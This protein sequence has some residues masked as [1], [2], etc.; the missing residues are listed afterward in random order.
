[1]EN[2]QKLAWRCCRGT[3]E[4]DV[5][6]QRFLNNYYQTASGDL[7]HA[8]ERMLDMQDPELYDLLVGRQL[9]EDQNINNVIE[10]IYR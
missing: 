2:L 9:S 3:K 5:L 4:L 1:M 10:H 6:M 8:F 7:Q